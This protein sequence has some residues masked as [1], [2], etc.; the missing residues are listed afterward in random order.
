MKNE[1]IDSITKKKEKGILCKLDIKKAYDTLNWNF[2][3]SSLQKRGFGERWIERIKW[4]ITTVSF[5]LIVYGSPADYFK[6]TRG[7]RQGNPLS[8]YLFVLGM[9]VFSILIDKAASGG[10]LFG[11]NLIGRIGEEVQVTYLLFAN[12]T[13]VFYKDSREQLVYLNWILMWFEAL[14]GLK[15]NISKSVLLPVGSVSRTRRI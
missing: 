15:I 12:D 8:P 3:L 9:E 14:S 6:S 5:S 11:F 13:L 1:E 7:L 10:L 4:C 2:L